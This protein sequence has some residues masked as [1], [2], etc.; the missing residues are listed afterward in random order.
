MRALRDKGKLIMNERNPFKT[1]LISKVELE[2][3][4]EKTELECKKIRNLDL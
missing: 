1:N 2:K 4:L 3:T